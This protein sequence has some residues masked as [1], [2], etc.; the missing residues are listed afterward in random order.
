[1]KFESSTTQVSHLP[2]AVLPG[3]ENFVQL[4]NNINTFQLGKILDMDP[5]E[6]LKIIHEQTNEIITDEF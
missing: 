3:E 1:M 6:L 5:I 4:P 2:E